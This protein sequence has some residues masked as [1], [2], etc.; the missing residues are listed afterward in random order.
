MDFK[1][2]Q[3]VLSIAKNN[4]I[5]KAAKELYISQPY[6]SKYLKNLEKNLDIK[7]FER[8]GNNFILTYAGERYIESAKKILRIKKELDNEF[9]DILKE[10]KGRIN[11]ACSIIRSPYLI[12]ETVPKF[13]KK[14]PDVK[15]NFIEETETN[16][17][18]ELVESGEADIAIFNYS[19]NN[20]L[21]NYKCLKDEEVTLAVSRKHPLANCGML[22]EGCNYPWIDINRFK[23][24][25]FIINY[26]EQKSGEMA[27]VIFDKY[28]INPNIVLKTR[29]VVGAVKL[30]AHNFGVT[31]AL[32]THIKHMDLKDEPVFFSIGNPKTTVKLFVVYRKDTYLPKYIEDY[33]NIVKEIL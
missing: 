18:D 4:S 10:K 21:L 13:K 16:N 17:L 9:F 27:E 12:S 14:Y 31:F 19:L 26:N 1:E 25:N 30:A 7:L 24:D 22:K 20:K 23:N 29:S 5:S 11:I 2:L 3:Y 33:I 32:E 28:N 8:E 15:I 6:L